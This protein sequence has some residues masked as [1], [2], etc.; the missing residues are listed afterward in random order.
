M[1]EK[2]VKHTPKRNAQKIKREREREGEREREKEKG[3]RKK[4]KE[5]HLKGAHREL[6]FFIRSP[7]Q[8]YFSLP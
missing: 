8:I 7:S 5:S 2:E 3:K 6:R 4:K 1:K